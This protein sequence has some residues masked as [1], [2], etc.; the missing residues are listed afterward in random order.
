LADPLL[1]KKKMG[2]AV[3]LSFSFLGFDRTFDL[4]IASLQ[5]KEGTDQPTLDSLSKQLFP[6]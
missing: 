3:N 6:Q 1:F 4:K 2:S 5:E